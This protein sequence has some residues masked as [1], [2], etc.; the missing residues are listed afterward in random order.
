MRQV[1]RR[2]PIRTGI[3]RGEQK[4]SAIQIRSEPYGDR[5]AQ[6]RTTLR[7]AVQDLRRTVPVSGGI[8]DSHGRPDESSPVRVL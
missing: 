5:I 1:Q 7:T 3:Y 4:V 2:F 8:E 6:F